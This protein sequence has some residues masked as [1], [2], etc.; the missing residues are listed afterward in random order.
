MGHYLTML[1]EVTQINDNSTLMTSYFRKLR[2]RRY[3]SQICK[4]QDYP[5]PAKHHVKSPGDS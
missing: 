1:Y 4:D 5:K 3:Q 2:I